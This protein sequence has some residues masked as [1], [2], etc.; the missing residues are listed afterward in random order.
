MGAKG[1]G[2]GCVRP[3]HAHMSFYLFIARRRLVLLS[4]ISHRDFVA[5]GWLPTFL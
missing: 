4:L 1:G 3:K 5:C 2:E